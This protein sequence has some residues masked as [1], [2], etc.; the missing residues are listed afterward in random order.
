MALTFEGYWREARS[1]AVHAAV[2][3]PHE[4][5]AAAHLLA[6]IPQ[7]FWSIDVASKVCCT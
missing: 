3:A 5:Q 2:A 1:Q 6:N 4:A 7:M